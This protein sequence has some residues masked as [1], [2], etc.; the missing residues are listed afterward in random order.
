M[1]PTQRREWVDMR[2]VALC[3]LI[4]SVAG[5]ASADTVLTSGAFFHGD[6]H[7]VF[8]NAGKNKVEVNIEMFDEEGGSLAVGDYVLNPNQSAFLSGSTNGIYSH[9]RFKGKFSAKSVR[10]GAIS[11]TTAGIDRVSAE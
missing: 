4:G 3:L 5:V 6:Q 9:C 7:C 8:L 11:F 10:A 2:T 1:V